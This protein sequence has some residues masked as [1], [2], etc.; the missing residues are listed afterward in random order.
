MGAHRQGMVL[1]A[2]GLRDRRE[3]AA[4]LRPRA[5]G[6]D[7]RWL[8]L[9]L[10][11]RL[12]LGAV[13]LWPLESQSRLRLVVGAGHVLGPGVGELARMRRLLRLGAAAAVGALRSGSGLPH[14]RQALGRGRGLRP[15]FRRLLL[16]GLRPLRRTRPAPSPR[17]SGA[18]RQYLPRQPGSCATIL[19]R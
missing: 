9:D 6:V 19:P 4:V 10:G 5:L 8:V 7:G 1:A 15:G 2:D 11:L 13:S 16:R 3:L 18:L 12:G 17:R 14:R